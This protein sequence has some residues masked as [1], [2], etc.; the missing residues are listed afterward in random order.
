M[1][2]AESVTSI[3]E[4]KLPIILGV[5]GKLIIIV[6]MF[7]IRSITYTYIYKKRKIYIKNIYIKI[8]SEQ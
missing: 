4:T 8:P 3:F 1:T 6:K 5:F 2:E 7:N